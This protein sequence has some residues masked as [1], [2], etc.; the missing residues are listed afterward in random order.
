M[1]KTIIN[2]ADTIYVGS[3]VNI[4]RVFYDKEHLNEKAFV[5]CVCVQMN[6]YQG[7]C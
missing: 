3:K 5:W 2:G 7:Q 6:A 1:N 4:I